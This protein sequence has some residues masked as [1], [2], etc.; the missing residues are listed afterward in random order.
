MIDQQTVSDDEF[1]D[2]NKYPIGSLEDN[3]ATTPSN[4]QTKHRLYCVDGKMCFVLKD[5]EFPSKV[6][7]D[8]GWKL[9]MLGIPL[10]ESI[11]SD[12]KKKACPIHPFC[13][14]KGMLLPS[15]AKKVFRLQYKPIFL[16]MEE[17]EGLQFRDNIDD[18]DADYLN[19][20]Q[21]GSAHLKKKVSYIFPKERRIKPLCWTIGMWCTQVAR[22]EIEKN[23]AIEDVAKLPKATKYN[24]TKLQIVQEHNDTRKRKHHNKKQKKN[25]RRRE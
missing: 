19:S 18:I 8:V 24:K 20:F 21:L 1:E 7:L 25:K 5:Y 11:D 3:N 2:T 12:G 6:L 14:I 4:N 23:G 22:F 13:L 10:Y 15:K 9:W 16:T 17:A